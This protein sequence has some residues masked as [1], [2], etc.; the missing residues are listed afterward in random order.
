MS[1]DVIGS[2]I[3]TLLASLWDA[4]GTDLLLTVGMPAQIRVDGELRPLDEKA[5]NLEKLARQTF[6]W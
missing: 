3:E 2:R 5:M 6:V 4:S 1:A